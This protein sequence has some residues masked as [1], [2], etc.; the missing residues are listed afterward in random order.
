MAEAG[1]TERAHLQEWV[2]E[3]PEMLGDGVLIITFE[4]DRWRNSSGTSERDR[5]DVLG[6][7]RKGTLVV[8]EL[9]R[10]AAPVGVQVIHRVFGVA[11]K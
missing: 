11:F 5:L 1:L 6:L 10:D 4:F 9:K 2:I 3:H 7:D 8:A